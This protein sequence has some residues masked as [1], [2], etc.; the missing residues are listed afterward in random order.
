M[1]NQF[2]M[3]DLGLL[4]YYLGIEV[5]QQHGEKQEGYANKILKLGGMNLCNPTQYPMESRLKLSKDENG[6][7][8]VP[9]EYRKLI[10]SL[11]YLTH[12]RPDLNYSVGMASRFMQQPKQSHWQVLKKILRYVKGTTSYGLCYKRDGRN[13]LVGF[14]DSSHG[15][16]LCDGRSTTG[17]T[18]YFGNALISWNSQKQQTVA[19]SSCESEFMA[20]AATACQAIWLK[21]LL[22][23]LTGGKEETVTLR[24]DNQSA[25]ALIKNPVFHGR[26]K[27]INTRFH[28]IREYVERGEI[29]V[30]HVP[31][32]EQKADILTKALPRIKFEE[33]R[34]LLGVVDLG[35]SS[36]D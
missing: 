1:K 26:S 24:V 11:R 29:K 5:S 8:V 2:E 9:T 22:S 4:T 35:G 6:Q 14:C 20:A 27:H 32:T 31:G 17:M 3:Q 21:G 12:T 36:K 34:K 7:D 16:D 19:L 28:F 10:G 25:I 30:E 15:T 33:M 13:E 18:F 23:D